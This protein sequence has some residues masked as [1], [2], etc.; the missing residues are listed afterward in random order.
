MPVVGN[1]GMPTSAMGHA[2]TSTMWLLMG[3]MLL[4]GHC[5]SLTPLLPKGNC[6]WWVVAVQGAPVQISFRFRASQASQLEAAHHVNLSRITSGSS[7]PHLPK[8]LPYP[9]NEDPRHAEHVSGF[10][11][12][13]RDCRP[14]F[15]YILIKSGTL[16]GTSPFGCHN[17]M[18]KRD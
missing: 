8:P 7:K 10:V 9:P 6:T 11:A 12:K 15:T 14:S 18:H 3:P 1:A 2:F 4:V 13:V 16:S 5:P 17:T